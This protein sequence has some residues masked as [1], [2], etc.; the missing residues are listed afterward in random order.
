MNEEQMFAAIGRKQAELDI[1][2]DEYDRVLLLLNKV[3]SGEIP[4]DEVAVDLSGRRWTYT[5][6][7]A[8]QEE[9][10]EHPHPL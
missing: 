1:L 10:P 4:H 8:L 3:V 7:P 6:N 2:N 5:P 9:P